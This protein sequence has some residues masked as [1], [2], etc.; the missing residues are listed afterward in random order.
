MMKF[1]GIDYGT[2]RIGLATANSKNKIATPLRVISNDGNA[3]KN[4]LKICQKK[5][6]DTI[7][8]GESKDRAGRDN[9]VM[10]YVKEFVAE[11][12]NA[13]EIDIIFADE[14]GSSVEASRQPNNPKHLDGSAAA[15]ILQRYLDRIYEENN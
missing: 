11:L 10:E 7:V 3:M 4:V 6:I 2:K 15:V 12:I 1:L 5:S 9:P 8:V 14:F 13:T